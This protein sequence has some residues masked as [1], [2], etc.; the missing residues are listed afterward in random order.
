MTS[1]VALFAWEVIRDWRWLIQ[2]KGVLT[3]FLKY[4]LLG[5]FI[6]MADWKPEITIFIVYCYQ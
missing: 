6:P 3:L 1:G 2:L 5:L 4:Y